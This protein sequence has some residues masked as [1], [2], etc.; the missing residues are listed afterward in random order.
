MTR[1]AP[2]WQAIS[3]NIYNNYIIFLQ[4]LHIYN[5][6]LVTLDTETMGRLGLAVCADIMWAQ[7]TVELA[8]TEQV[9]GYSVL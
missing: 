6:Q 5:V 8:A 2:R 1:P 3:N 9:V 4:Y 7:P